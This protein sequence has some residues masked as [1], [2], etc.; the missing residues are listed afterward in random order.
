MQTHINKIYDFINKHL[1]YSYVDEVIEYFKEK[2]ITSPSKSTIRKVRTRV[3]SSYEIR[4]DILEALVE[5]A[6]KNKE[7]VENLDQVMQNL[8]QKI[9]A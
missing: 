5:V 7:A 6:T 2:N 9:S 3:S 8:N 4:F 1:P